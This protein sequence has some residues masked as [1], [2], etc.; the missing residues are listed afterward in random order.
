M[1]SRRYSELRLKDIRSCC[2]RMFFKIDGTL[3]NFANFT[4]KHLRWNLFLIKL[5]ALK[6]KTSLKTV[7]DNGDNVTEENGK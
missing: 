4:G 1:L 6:L 3:Q 2:S 5:Q 7:K